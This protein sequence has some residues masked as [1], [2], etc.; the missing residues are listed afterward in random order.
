MGGV[1]LPLINDPGAA[2]INPAALGDMTGDH[3]ELSA[4]KGLDAI[5]Q[6]SF[7]GIVLNAGRAGSFGINYLGY[8]SG[9]EEIYDLNGNPS[10]ITLEK[11]Y[12]VSAGWGRNLG[13]ELFFGGQAKS[14]NSKLAETYSANAVTFD[15][16]IMYKSLDDNFTLGA[17]V[18]NINGSLKYKTAADPLPR[19]IRG[20]A[21]YRFQVGQDRF[22]IGMTAE[23]PS[24]AASLNGGAGA[25]YAF[26]ALPLAVR[27]GITRFNDATSLTTGIGVNIKGIS[28]DYGFQPAGDLGE[29]IQR[30]SLCVNFGSSDDASRALIFKQR[31]L[32]RKALAMGYKYKGPRIPVSVLQPETGGGVTAEQGAAIADAIRSGLGK[33]PRLQLIAREETEQVLKEQRFQ[34]SV[35]ASSD[36]AVEA[37][38][39][40]GARKIF[41]I[42]ALKVGNEYSL[43]IKA[44][45]V[46]TGAQDYAFTGT[47]STVDGL[48]KLAVKFADR[49]ALGE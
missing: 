8:D 25:E 44:V 30:F 46:E 11:D 35:C 12:A 17:G 20:E 32:K 2:Y 1:Y 10:D 38:K 22:T 16:G 19:V 13:E 33:S 14:V 24:D 29:A 27:A 3:I 48:Y 18:Q 39:L 47:A 21:G 7:A 40:L 6:Y 34:Y 28:L 43:T 5:S 15:A 9:S 26:T 37:G 36:C 42:S 4:W 45:D 41:S 49:V 31:G 23:K